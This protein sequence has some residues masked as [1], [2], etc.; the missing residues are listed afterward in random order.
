VAAAAAAAVAAADQPQEQQQQGAQ[1][2]SSVE[3]GGLSAD[4]LWAACA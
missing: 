3:A 1:G 2:R 4:S